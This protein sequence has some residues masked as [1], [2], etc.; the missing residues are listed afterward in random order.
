MDIH[1]AVDIEWY[2]I[3]GNIV[4]YCYI[5]VDLATK[6]KNKNIRYLYEGINDFKRG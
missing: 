1:S 2:K 6:S 3:I 5:P 4:N